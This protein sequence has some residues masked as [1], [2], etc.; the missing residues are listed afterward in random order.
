MVRPPLRTPRLTL[1]C[2]DPASSNDQDFVIALLNDPAW[3]AN[4]GKRDVSTRQ[5][6]QAYLRDGPQA[7]FE[8]LGF[9]LLCVE[10]AQGLPVG[11][12]GL[13]QRDHLPAP[14]IGFAFLPQWRGRGLAHEAAEATLGWAQALGMGRV[15]AIVTPGNGPSLG[16]LARLGFKNEGMVDQSGQQLH[17]LAWSSPS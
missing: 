15:L 4:I 14:D 12:C 6:A 1:R 17:L 2:F 13:I 7:L 10:A 11:M 8:R 3:I 16:L 5:Q 9:G